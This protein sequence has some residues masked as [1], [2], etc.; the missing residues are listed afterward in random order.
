MSEIS[1]LLKEALHGEDEV[2]EPERHR[3]TLQAS[4]R[5]FDARMKTIRNF[6]WFAVG[7]LGGFGIYSLCKL[8]WADD[9]TSPRILITWAALFLFSMSGV[10]TV[11][12]WLFLT[13]NN[14]S[15]QKELKRLQMRLAE[16]A[17]SIGER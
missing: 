2:L 5:K 7:A 16:I 12:F 11:K 14:V 1:N 8:L 4:V 10:G 15:I 3:E 13:Q 17:A 6:A 9:A